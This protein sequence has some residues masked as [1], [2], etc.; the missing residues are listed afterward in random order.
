MLE[1]LKSHVQFHF[2]MKATSYG[3]H[4]GSRYAA[5]VNMQ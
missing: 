3:S 2:G 1:G 5:N 4:H